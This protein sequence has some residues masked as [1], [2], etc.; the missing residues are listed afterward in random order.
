MTFTASTPSLSLRDLRIGY[1]PYG[2]TLSLPGDSRRFVYYAKKRG[3]KFELANPKNEYDLVILSGRADISVWNHYPKAKLVY[4]LIDSYLAVP[5][6][7]VKG[8]LRGLF[9]FISRQSHYLQLDYWKAIGAMC[10]RADAV[11]CSTHEQRAD[12]MRYCANVHVILDAHMGVTRSTKINYSAHTPFKLVWEGLPHTLHSLSLIQPAIERLSQ[13]YPIELH[14]ITDREHYRYLSQFYKINTQKKLHKIFPKA[15][16]HDWTASNFADIACECD[17]AVI[18]LRLS[19]PF[20][21]GKPEN[22]LLLFWRMGIPVITSATPAYMRA[23][24]SAGLDL[25]VQDEQGWYIAIEK[26]LQNEALRHQAGKLGKDYTEQQFS[27]SILLS[28]WDALFES[29]GFSVDGPK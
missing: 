29:L 4:D 18:P 6:S 20:A 26:L 12:I 9:K 22:K 13:K 15:H 7:D 1:V 5:R 19:D 23:M 25:A 21:S 10:A 27:E 17:L 24:Q 28:K 16:F 8:R 3:I 11:V 2:E 14:V